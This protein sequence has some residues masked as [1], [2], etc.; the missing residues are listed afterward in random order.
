MKTENNYPN[1]LIAFLIKWSVCLFLFLPFFSS[2]S[3]GQ[4]SELSK[5]LRQQVRDIYTSQIGIREIGT[6]TGPSV[7]R[8]L[9]YVN[10][11]KGNPWCAAF[12]CWVYG[13]AGIEN[14]KTGWSPSLFPFHKVIWAKTENYYGKSGISQN[15]SDTNYATGIGMFIRP[16]RQPTTANRQPYTADIFALYFPEKKR[17]AHA[18]FIDQWDGNWLISVEGNTNASGS[19][20]GDGVYRKRRPVKSVYKVARYINY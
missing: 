20:E 3:T 16:V 2:V 6:N 1:R 19:N 9:S 18:G 12:V 5:K 14:P 11:S 15:V 8:Y 13:Q 7:E 10:L 4:E 17:I